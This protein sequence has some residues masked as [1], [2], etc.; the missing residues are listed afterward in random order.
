ML[1]THLMIRAD[2][3]PLQE[4]PDAFD[5]VGVNVADNPFLG[6]VIN[7]PVLGVGIFDAPISRHFIRVDRFRVRRGIVTDELLQDRFSRVRDNL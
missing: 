3:R 5:S 2:N 7:P 4:T 1:N 6:G